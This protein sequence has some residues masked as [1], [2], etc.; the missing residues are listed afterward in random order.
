MRPDVAGT[1]YGLAMRAYIREAHRIVAET[2]IIEEHVGV[3][4]RAAAGLPDHAEHYDDSVGLGSYRIDLHPSTGAAGTPRTYV[5]VSSY[6]FE[7]PLGSLI[8]QRVDNLLAGGKNIGTTHITNGCY[9]LHPVE[10]NIGEAAGAAAAFALDRGVD[11][12][13]IRAGRKLLDEFQRLLVSEL[14]ISLAWPDWA[15]AIRN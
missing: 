1:D 6:P 5:D 13:G 2:R 7:I 11:P 10:W 8:P 9:R 14:G 12:R 15:R 3:E 4:A